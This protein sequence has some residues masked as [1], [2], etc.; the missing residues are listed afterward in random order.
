LC[1]T[2]IEVNVIDGQMEFDDESYCEKYDLDEPT[3]N[4]RAEGLRGRVCGE[5]GLVTERLLTS[6]WRMPHAHPWRR[7]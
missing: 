5:N 2:L 6:L 7:R 3:T 1:T 4:K